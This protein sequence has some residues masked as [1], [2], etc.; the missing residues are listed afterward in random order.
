MN[1]ESLR[2]RSEGSGGG[3][4]GVEV[5]LVLPHR[6]TDTGELIGYSTGGLVEAVAGLDL[7][8]PVL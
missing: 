8:S 3:V 1:A 4:V 6:P 2:K 5:G 7:A